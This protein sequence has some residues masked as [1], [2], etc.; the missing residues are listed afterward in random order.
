MTVV[1]KGCEA[2]GRVKDIDT[3]V[4][5]LFAC[6]GFSQTK[7]PVTLINRIWCGILS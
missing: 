2:R 4:G 1:R 5:R 6:N 7:E 3:Q